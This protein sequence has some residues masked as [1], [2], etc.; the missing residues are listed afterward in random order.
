MSEANEKELD[1]PSGPSDPF[2]PGHPR[3]RKLGKLLRKLPLFRPF[4]AE[5]DAFRESIAVLAGELHFRDQQ[6]RNEVRKLTLERDRFA[7]AFAPGHYYSSVPG[8]PEIRSREAAIF[9]RVPDRIPGIDLNEDGQLQFLSVLAEFYRDLPFT[10]ERQPGLRYYFEN[11][12]FSYADG[13]ALYSMIRHARPRR[14]VEVG[15]GFS[16][17]AALDTNERF[18]A[19]SIQLTFVDPFPQLLQALLF[20]GDADRIRIIQD[21][22]QDV[23]LRTFTQLQA[24]DILFV[25]SSHVLRTAG[26]LNHMLFQ[27]LP[28]VKP[29]VYVHFHDIPFP[30]EYPREWVFE[31]RAWNECYALRAFLQ[32]NSAYEI[33]YFNSFLMR[34]HREF[35]EQRMPLWLRRPGGSLWL[36]KIGAAVTPE[37][38][39]V[40]AAPFEPTKRFEAVRI[41]HPQQLGRGWYGCDHDLGSRWMGLWSELILKAPERKGMNLRLAGFLPHPAGATLTLSSGGLPIGVSRLD[42][43]TFRLSFALP[44]ALVGRER[45]VLKLELD[46]TYREQRDDRDLGMSFGIIEVV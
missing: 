42:Q 33:L 12:N 45:F 40:P 41:A 32:H 9:D 31:G 30:F 26:D 37:P 15:C 19:N 29:G 13:I 18:F 27:V 6:R 22:V 38:E 43:G 7:T 2:P 35:I 34:S 10:P 44:D 14:I 39:E 3:A 20:P 17:C 21:Y 23:P 4:F 11:P 16:S 24:N 8:L 5:R 25:D 1:S 46:K 28:Y 36:R